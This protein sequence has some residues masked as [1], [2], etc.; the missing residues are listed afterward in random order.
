MSKLSTYAVVVVAVGAAFISSSHAQPQ[1]GIMGMMGG[2]CPSIGMMD[3]V[4]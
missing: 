4:A 1:Q 2:G 3:T